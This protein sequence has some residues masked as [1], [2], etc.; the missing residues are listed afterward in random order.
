MT[1]TDAVNAIIEFFEEHED[2][3]IAA[4]EDLDSYNGYLGDDRYYCMDELD[5]LYADAAPSEI[6]ARAFYGHD[7]DSY[8]TLRHEER[9]HAEFNPNREYFRFNGYGNLVSADWKD[10]S[11]RLDKWFVENLIENAG[12]LYEIPEE[13]ENIIDSIDEEVA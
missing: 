6:L 5:E 1:R 10:Y 7:E 4:I 9:K 11:D 2:E 13:V 12:H 8:I 3:F